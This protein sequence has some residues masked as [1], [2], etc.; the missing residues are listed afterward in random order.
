MSVGMVFHN[1]FKVVAGQT[2]PEDALAA[3][4]YPA[5][6]S[7]VDIRGYDRVHLLIHLGAIAGSDAPVF[8]VQSADAANGTPADVD[9]TNLRFTGTDAD[10]DEFVTMTLDTAVLTDTHGWLTCDVSGTLVG[11]YADIV[12]LLEGRDKPVTQPATL[13][14]ANQLVKT[15]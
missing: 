1:K 4:K 5:S 13:P 8:T 3:G 11:S 7:F 2:S 10:D 12:W 15:T 14:A 6:A 9:T